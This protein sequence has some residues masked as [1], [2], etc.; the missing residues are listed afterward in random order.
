MNNTD[1]FL[2]SIVLQLILLLPFYF[3]HSVQ[4]EELPLNP[5]MPFTINDYFGVPEPDESIKPTK[6]RP[7]LVAEDIA[8]F[9]FPDNFSASLPESVGEFWFGKFSKCVI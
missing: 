7:C 4:A 3:Q 9:D 5:R 1:R 8:D 2:T 6:Y